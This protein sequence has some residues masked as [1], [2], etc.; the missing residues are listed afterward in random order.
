MNS[1]KSLYFIADKIQLRTDNCLY[2]NIYWLHEFLSTLLAD[3]IPKYLGAIIR[4]VFNGKYVMNKSQLLELI[5]DVTTLLEKYSS[6]PNLTELNATV[7]YKLCDIVA[8]AGYSILNKEIFDE[9]LNEHLK[10]EDNGKAHPDKILSFL[11]GLAHTPDNNASISSY[12]LNNDNMDQVYNILK[13]CKIASFKNL[14]SEASPQSD[15]TWVYERNA[16]LPALLD[17]KILLK[18]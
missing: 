12:K 16:I 10:Y 11:L 2:H 14:T 6:C 7:Q 3:I 9:L 5:S 8:E 13:S 18:N 1:A 15:H 17:N 4:Y